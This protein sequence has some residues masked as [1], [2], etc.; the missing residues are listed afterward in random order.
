MNVRS[1][2]FSFAL[3]CLLA[4]AGCAGH[5]ATS[6]VPGDASRSEQ[7]RPNAGG[8]AAGGGGPAPSPGPPGPLCVTLTAPST[9]L[10]LATISA[11]GQLSRPTVTNNIQLANCSA[12]PQI[13]TV[14]YTI[15]SSDP[16]A[17][18][19]QNLTIPDDIESMNKLSSKGLSVNVTIPNCP[20][21]TT[22]TITAKV[23]DPN[24]G[25]LASVATQFETSDLALKPGWTQAPNEPAG[26]QVLNAPVVPD[27]AAP[28]GVAGTPMFW[29]DGSSEL[30]KGGFFAPVDDG[31]M[32]GAFVAGGFFTYADASGACNGTPCVRFISMHGGQSYFLGLNA[33][34]LPSPVQL[35][36]NQT[37]RL[38]ALGDTIDFY[39]I[40]APPPAF[41]FNN[42]PTLPIQIT[43]PKLGSATLTL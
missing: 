33:P 8:G 25:L 34:L 20:G 3:V 18:C 41:G 22:Y 29:F 7:G 26:V 11:A 4:A 40:A 30:L 19:G 14:T 32:V 28:P 9:F 10:G 6:P 31:Q 15:A 1:A 16:Y 37:G 13:A 36:G 27:P 35:L 39:P 24:R 12:D 23:T 38:L 5:S 42:F 43:G 21:T 2:G 17:G